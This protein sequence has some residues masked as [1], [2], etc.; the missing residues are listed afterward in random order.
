MSTYTIEDL[1]IMVYDI[2]NKAGVNF[3]GPVE[4]NS[5]LLTTLGR[6][7]NVDNKPIRVE[8]SKNFIENATD[9]TVISVCKHECAHIIALVRSGKPQHHN[10]YFKSI[11]AELGTT[12]DGTTTNVERSVAGKAYHR[13]TIICPNCGEIG[14]RQKMCASLRDIKNCW[15][16]K[17][18]ESTVGKLTYIQ[19]W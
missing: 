12:N 3:T 6:V 9:E 4:L 15:C 10:S 1:K 16:V 8:F 13:Y 17:C 7:M 18:G 14:S 5:R 19:N 2:C 11:C